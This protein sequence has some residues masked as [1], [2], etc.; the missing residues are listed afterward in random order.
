[1]AQAIAE[2]IIRNGAI[3]FF[4]THFL[5]LAKTLAYKPNVVALNLAADVQKDRAETRLV[6]THKIQ[7]G[8]TRLSHYGSFRVV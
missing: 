2:A 4:A 6:F 5:D 7:D 1:M 3:C 8:V